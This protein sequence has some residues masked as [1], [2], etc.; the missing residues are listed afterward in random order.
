MRRAGATLRRIVSALTPPRAHAF[1]TV[2]VALTACGGGLPWLRG[3]LVNHPAALVGEWIDV[4]KSAP[5]DSSIWV[6][7]ANGNDE[8]LSITRDSL[9]DA[10]ARVSRRHYGYWYVRGSGGTQ[11]FC[12]NR[13]PGRDAPSCT[14]FTI[15]VDSSAAPP[16]SAL[17][18]AA[19][20]GAHHTSERVLVAR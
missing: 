18:L 15:G 3:D 9:A 19:Y 10:R 16:R 20:S 11:E 2:L 6:L 7:S 14:R 8:V 5:A 12:V 13:R 1:V 4:A 17:R